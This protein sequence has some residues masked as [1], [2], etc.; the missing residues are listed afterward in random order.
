MRSLCGYSLLARKPSSE[1]ER[2]EEP[3][4]HSHTSS[5]GL[6]EITVDRSSLLPSKICGLMMVFLVMPVMIGG[7]GN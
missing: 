2:A 1:E 5:L 3:H 4:V 7:F 6:L